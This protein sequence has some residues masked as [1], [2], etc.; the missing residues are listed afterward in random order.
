M[1]PLMKTIKRLT[2][3]AFCAG[4]AT[5]PM[6]VIADEPV[7]A[8]PEPESTWDADIALGF[9]LTA[10]NS[11]TVLFTLQY[12]AK[13]EWERDIWSLGASGSYGEDDG[14]KN[15]EQLGGHVDYQHLFSERMYGGANLSLL[16]DSIANLEFRATIG[17]LIGYYFIKNETTRLSGEIGPSYVVEKLHVDHP[18]Q[19]PPDDVT[20]DWQNYFALRLG[21]RFEHQLSETAKVWQSLEILPQI[22]DFNNF[23]LVAEVGVEAALNSDLSVRVVVADKYDNDVAEGTKKNDISVISSLVYRF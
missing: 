21:E 17:P 8:E 10:G 19:L 5:A 3:F 9:N 15:N 2:L 23:L 22:D 12:Q 6:A 20:S 4:L 13:R 18:G 11:D 1:R 16:H 7:V 14:E